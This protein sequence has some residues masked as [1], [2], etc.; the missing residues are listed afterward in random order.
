[1]QPIITTYSTKEP[2]IAANE[3]WEKIYA[4]ISLNHDLVNVPDDEGKTPLWR[5]M[6]QY[7]ENFN[8]IKG[9]EVY[10]FIKKLIDNKIPLNIDAAPT[11]GSHR[12]AS[13]LWL[14]LKLVTLLEDDSDYDFQYS[15]EMEIPLSLVHYFLSAYPGCNVN[16]A[17][18]EG[19][20]AWVTAFC[21][22]LGLYEL[23]PL[24][25][26]LKAVLH[27]TPIIFDSP[28][29]PF[30]SSEL[31]EKCHVFYSLIKLICNELNSNLEENSLSDH[32]SY[33]QTEISSDQENEENMI[34]CNY[35]HYLT[36]ILQINPESDVNFQPSPLSFEA[37]IWSTEEST[38][39][40]FPSLKA[41]NPLELVLT[42]PPSQ[43]KDELLVCLIFAGARPTETLDAPL[44]EE[45]N[46]ILEKIKA[47]FYKALMTFHFKFNLDEN[48]RLPSELMEGIAVDMVLTS[49]PELQNFPYQRIKEKIAHGFK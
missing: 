16:S 29:P 13:V 14:L 48:S 28:L 18:E 8:S 12:G 24:D 22:M 40:S 34:S 3:D 5:A 9:E 36:K 37:N 27:H 15:E 42:L 45:Y 6:F 7:M 49:L 46:K 31:K 35:Y 4:D 19:E 23:K 33:S 17:P 38:C 21:L 43:I 26:M 47:V 11:A 30:K 1:M 41:K 20:F 2:K 32:E 10:S 39:T 44:L 25:P